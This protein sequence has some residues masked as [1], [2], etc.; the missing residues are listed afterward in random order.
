MRVS[1]AAKLGKSIHT[2]TVQ[3]L[4]KC[5]GVP[6]ELRGLEHLHKKYGSLPWADLVQPAIKV[7]RYGFPVNNDTMSFMKRTYT[8]SENES[9]LVNDPAWAIDFA[10]SGK[11]V[12]IGEK[13][14]R[15]RFADTLEAIADGGP[16]VFYKVPL[17]TL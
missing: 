13:L 8:K 14:T 16:D 4:T 2:L 11:L 6:G 5:S 10:P 3:C 15:R 7:A 17:L 1:T 9:F 12:Q